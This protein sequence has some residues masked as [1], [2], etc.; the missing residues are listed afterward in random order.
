MT[1]NNDR[2]GIFTVCSTHRSAGDWFADVNAIGSQTVST[3]GGTADLDP[4]AIAQAGAW[5]QVTYEYYIKPVPAPAPI[6][7]LALGAL[8]LAGVRRMKK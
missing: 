1:G 6:A 5:M 3:S 8:G 4:N 2:Y 7:L